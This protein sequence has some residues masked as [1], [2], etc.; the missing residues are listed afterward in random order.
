MR[1]RLPSGSLFRISFVA[2][3]S[4]APAGSARSPRRPVRKPRPCTGVPLRI[5]CLPPR[6]R[7]RAGRRCAEREKFLLALFHLIICP[8][9]RLDHDALCS[10]TF[11]RSCQVQ[12]SERC[13]RRPYIR[14]RPLHSA[15]P[16]LEG[17]ASPSPSLDHRRQPLQGTCP[18]GRFP[19]P[20]GEDGVV[21]VCQHV[22]CFQVLP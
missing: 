3:R 16:A 4:R 1:K 19:S 15:C 20:S 6:K 12:P 11:N 22:T 13:P 21:A 10:G 17:N 5:G 14:G 18:T 7:W 9:V 2:E 8:N